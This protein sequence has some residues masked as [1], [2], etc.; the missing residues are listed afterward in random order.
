MGAVELF[1][2]S[3]AGLGI[4]F[5]GIKMVTRNLGA[6][7]GSRLRA[8][9]TRVTRRPV[10]A[11]ATGSVLGFLAQSG[12]TASFIMA[13]FVHAGMVEARSAVTVS[14]WSNFGCALVAVAAVFPLH[15]FA[16]FVLALAGVIIAFELPRPLLRAASAVFGLALMLFGLGM[17]SQAALQLTQ[18]GL[19]TDA[20]HLVDKSL[21]L[22]FLCGLVLTFV[23]Q[24]HIAIMLISVALARQGLLG[25]EQTLMLAFGA[26]LGS[27]LITFFTGFNFRGAPRQVVVAEILY[28]PIVVG[29]F[30]A[31]F[32]GDRWLAGGAGIAALS[33]NAGAVAVGVVIAANLAAPVLLTLLRRPYL[34][35][36]ERLSPPLAAEELAHPRYLHHDFAGSPHTTLLLAEKEQRRLFERFPAY[37]AAFDER[38]DGDAPTP[39]VYHEAFGIVGTEI[40]QTQARLMAREMSRE[41]TEWLLAQQKR[42]H[43]LHALDEACFELWQA[44]HALPEDLYAMRGKIVDEL[45]V[46]L[47]LADDAMTTRNP[48]DFRIIEAKT[49]DCGT[50]METM[51]EDYL[52]RHRHHSPGERSQV[53][54]LTS[55]YERAAWAIRRLSALLEKRPVLLVDAAP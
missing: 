16:L 6:I 54:A 28:N 23:A 45:A 7:A 12:R 51:R 18:Q 3:L 37:C 40:E 47:A 11:M 41:D 35:L 19:F 14:L 10:A 27:S 55:V 5:F 1:M 50:R 22:A 17:M 36:C 25:L 9:V 38:T 43:V 39:A 8:G 21:A 13:T 15:L 26:H 46:L 29:L 49:R 31:V 33:G 2:N 53:L 44:G 20:L 32:L 34:R 52:A 24:S 42:Q 48:E 4:L 30:L